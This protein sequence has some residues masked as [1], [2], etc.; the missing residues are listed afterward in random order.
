MTKKPRT[1]RVRL[2][3][4][5]RASLQEVIKYVRGEKVGVIVHRVKPNRA[6][7]RSAR[8]KL[9]LSLRKTSAQEDNAEKLLARK[10]T[11]PDDVEL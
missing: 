2:A 3:D 5:L 7:A 4:D 8:R 1:R 9:G 10:G 11:V 6:K